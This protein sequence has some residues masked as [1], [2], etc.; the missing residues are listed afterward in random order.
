MYWTQSKQNILVAGHRGN[1]SAAPENTMVSF[2][3]AV[4]AGVDML[5]LDIQ[6]TKDKKLILMHNFT[7][8]NT[9]NGSGAVKDLT[10]AQ[11]RT[12]DAGCKFS[13]VF[14]G[15]KVPLFTEFLEHFSKYPNL[16]FNFEIK[17]YPENGNDSRAY[18]TADLVIDLIE[19][20]NLS[21]R[22]VI[23]AFSAKLLRYIHEKYNGKY[24]LHGFYPKDLLK[25]EKDF[26]PYPILYCVCVWD[27]VTEETFSLLKAK[28]IDTWV[29]PQ[30]DTKEALAY[31]HQC[32]A[33]V[34]TCNNPP[35]ILQLL[36]DMGLH[37]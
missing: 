29:G 11:I 31:I 25:P 8:D 15:E 26:D 22:C 3:S 14:S 16:L 20:Y 32:G 19:Q 6:M 35:Y 17:E 2:Q 10:L 36:R 24:K 30:F 9:T 23:N 7:V 5:E 27:K 18:E 21:Q 33:T 28:G 34:I 1:P 4:D 37:K 13:P 12:L